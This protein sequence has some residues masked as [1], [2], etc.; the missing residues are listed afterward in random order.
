MTGSRRATYGRRLFGAATV[1]AAL[2][3]GAACQPPGAPVQTGSRV[4][5]TTDP[6][7]FPGF[8]TDIVDYVS[9]CTAT[10]P[11]DV[12][13]DAPSGSS[14]SVDGAAPESGTFTAQVPL[15]VGQRFTIVVDAGAVTTTHYVR[16]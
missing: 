3:I 9:R 13:V 4:Q 11:V 1:A 7:L 12:H 15:D 8:R 6:T 2:L 10:E 14:V 16:C 5:I